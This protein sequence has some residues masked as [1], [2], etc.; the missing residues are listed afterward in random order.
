MT[1]LATYILRSVFNRKFMAFDEHQEWLYSNHACKI[2]WLIFF[3][4]GIGFNLSLAASANTTTPLLVAAML[5]PPVVLY[6]RQLFMQGTDRAQAYSPPTNKVAE[7]PKSYGVIYVLKRSDGVLKFGK[8]VDLRT[9]IAA[10]R[11]DYE[12]GFVAVA[13]WI[14]PD[15]SSYERAALS[16]TERY[17]YYEGNR[18]ELRIM[19]DYELSE[20]ILEFTSRVQN[21]FSKTT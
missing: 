7:H 16:M 4:F 17:A 2:A 12:Q 15:P 13:A 20:F 8:T 14:V 5:L 18:R 21:G 19:S 3:T 1:L 9:R 10:H 6:A 11:S